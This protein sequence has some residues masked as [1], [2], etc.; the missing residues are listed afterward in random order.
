MMRDYDKAVK[1][2]TKAIEADPQN[3]TYLSNRS[4]KHDTRPSMASA[5]MILETIGVTA[6]KDRDEAIKK[7]KNRWEDVE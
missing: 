4:R 1:E 3:P 7:A 5:Q 2:Y 6:K